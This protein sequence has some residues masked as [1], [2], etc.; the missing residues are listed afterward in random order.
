VKKKFG[1]PKK[2]KIK[3]KNKIK[4]EKYLVPTLIRRSRLINSS[5]NFLKGGRM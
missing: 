5:T 2:I 1:S 4:H 3:I